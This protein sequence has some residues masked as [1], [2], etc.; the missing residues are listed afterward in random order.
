MVAAAEAEA[1]ADA[2]AAA[3]AKP[4]VLVFVAEDELSLLAATAFPF[5]T[6]LAGAVADVLFLLQ[7]STQVLREADLLP[8][9]VKTSESSELFGTAEAVP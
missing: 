5:F 3:A 2:G 7:P 4:V 8:S 1:V 9:G 6:M